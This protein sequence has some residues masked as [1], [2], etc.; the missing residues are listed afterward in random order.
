[1]GFGGLQHEHVCL[2]VLQTAAD[3]RDE[4][5]KRFAKEAASC[6]SV[7]SASGEG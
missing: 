7:L 5:S 4:G 3:A 6:C 2:I 1:V